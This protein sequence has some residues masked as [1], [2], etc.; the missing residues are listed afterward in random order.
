M[1]RQSINRS[2]RWWPLL[3]A[4]SLPLLALC[5][6]ASAQ[7]P[8][9]E[10]QETATLGVTTV[11]PTALFQYASLV[12]SA[13][14]ITISRVPVTSSSG[15]TSYHDVTLTFTATSSGGVSLSGNKIVNSPNLITA[16]FK[17]GEYVA[18]ANTD[19]GV[20]YITVAG[21]G[22]ISGTSM[23]EW[24]LSVPSGAAGCTTP[25]DA[26]WYVG[27]IASNPLA[28]RLQAAK[29]T[30]P[31][32]SYGYGA[33]VCQSANW[34]DNIILGVSQIGNTITIASF[35]QNGVDKSEP[36]DQITFT[37]HQ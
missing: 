14:S 16:A 28:S 34:G 15:T 21:P 27:P 24:T 20:G 6:A 18:P 25:T 23:T 19:Y 32:W 13:N 10:L 36:V 8:D 33:A 22:V 5:S 4:T 7:T 9:T 1:K 35:T 26:T 29:I 3:A 12:G 37:A 2:R 31:A 11:T 17:A 30:S